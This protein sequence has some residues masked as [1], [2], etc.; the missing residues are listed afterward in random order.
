MSY[1][2][3]HKEKVS[4]VNNLDTTKLNTSLNS[5]K[6]KTSRKL[7]NSHMRKLDTE[8]KESKSKNTN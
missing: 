4:H 3:H 7:K 8:I 2:C 6:L 5:K 1:K